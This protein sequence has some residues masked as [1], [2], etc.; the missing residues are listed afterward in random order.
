LSNL[1]YKLSELFSLKNPLRSLAKN[2]GKQPK[3]KKLTYSPINLN[4]L[5][6]ATKSK[7]ISYIL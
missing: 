4:N 1:T 7:V 5:P 3:K 6:E 2:V